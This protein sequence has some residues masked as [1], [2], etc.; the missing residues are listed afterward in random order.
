MFA[1]APPPFALYTNATTLI[2]HTIKERILPM[3][4]GRTTPPAANQLALC[5]CL[6]DFRARF[7]LSHLDIP[8]FFGTKSITLVA[9][10]L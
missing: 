6:H 5:A 2:V 1:P 10:G 4:H 9:F 8:L 3:L 7:L